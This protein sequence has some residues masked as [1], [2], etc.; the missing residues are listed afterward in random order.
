M[1]RSSVV[2][3]L[4]VI[5][6][7]A[8]VVSA[9][10]PCS[11]NTVRGTYAVETKGQ[12]FQG[13]ISP[14]PGPG[15]LPLL[16][17]YLLPIYAVG[18]MTIA[19]DGSAVGAFAGQF[20]IMPYESNDWTAT[21]SVNPDCS[22]ELEYQTPF[23]TTNIEKIVIL[24]NGR[25]IRTVAIAAPAA[26]HTNAV[27]LRRANGGG[28]LCGPNTVRGTYVMRCDG[29]EGDPSSMTF[30]SVDDMFLL[31]VAADGSITGR[32]F[33][34]RR[35]PEGNPIGGEVTVKPDCTADLSLEAAV[36]GGTLVSEGKAVFYDNGNEM[37]GAPLYV[38]IGDTPVPA[39]FAG[40]GCH[41]TRLTR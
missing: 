14:V 33:G 31:E 6:G 41:A 9:E 38:K 29:L 39:P 22:G 10:A 1:K 34:L 27:R 4:I 21:V 18:T 12:L 19:R 40:S 30:G 28:P 5:L 3:L 25:E 36:P 24:D 15:G 11:L 16:N 13:G 26:F 7:A 32:H 23:G 37:F 17:G 20:G 35:S 2:A 8:S